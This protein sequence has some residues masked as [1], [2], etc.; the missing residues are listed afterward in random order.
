MLA[1][2][3][4]GCAVGH[5]D[6]TEVTSMDAM[7]KLKVGIIGSGKIGTDL[8]IKIMRSPF[9]RCDLFVGRDASSHGLRKALSL[10]VPISDQSLRAF[11]D[12]ELDL[13]FDATSAHYHP[14]HASYFKARGI[15]VIDMTPA[16]VG[17]FC[18]PALDVDN[19]ISQDNINMV[20]CGGQASVP[21]ATTLAR[22]FSGIEH[23]EVQSL[24]AKDSVGPGTLA[25]L[26]E[27]Y[28]T[29]ARALSQYSGIQSVKVDLQVERSNW[30]P[31]MLTLIRTHFRDNADCDTTELFG[32]LSELLDKIRLYAS[33]YTIVGTPAFNQGALEILICVRG[34]GDW[35]PCHAGNLDIINC[36]AIAVA[37]RFAVRVSLLNQRR[38]QNHRYDE[39]IRQQVLS[40]GR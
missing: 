19:A 36:A 10:G 7:P 39:A 5:G 12:V 30:K 6:Y 29:T 38:Q 21:V 17:G 16:Q 34:R 2:Y 33:G 3:C 20:T 24:V 31:D 1:P 32:P 27:Y 37:E 22:T 15:K 26:D 13:V 40:A 8:L 4:S 14:E 25:N 9:L 35:I 23:I 11:A 18:I 28:S